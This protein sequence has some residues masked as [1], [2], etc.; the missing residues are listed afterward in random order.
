MVLAAIRG[1]KGHW[2]AVSA[3]APEAPTSQ[4][5]GFR[6]GFRVTVDP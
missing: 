6:V 1:P 2:E 3:G 4:L 5:L